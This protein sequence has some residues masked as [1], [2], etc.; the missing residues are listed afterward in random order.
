[1][2][3]PAVMQ[4]LTPNSALVVNRLMRDHGVGVDQIIRAAVDDTMES[5]ER[6][7]AT[8]GKE[9]GGEN[10]SDFI[11]YIKRLATGNLGRPSKWHLGPHAIGSV[12]FYDVFQFRAIA[13]LEQTMGSIHQQRRAA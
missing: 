10:E 11:R 1:M 12:G 8:R 7:V 6:D 2:N 3:E 9:S 5:L 13:K 4:M